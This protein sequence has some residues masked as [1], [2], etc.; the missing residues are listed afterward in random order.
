MKDFTTPANISPI[1]DEIERNFFIDRPSP[2]V[3]NIF[4]CDLELSPVD[5]GRERYFITENRD[6]LPQ[7]FT[8]IFKD[9]E[10]YV[11][12]AETYPGELYTWQQYEIKRILKATYKTLINKYSR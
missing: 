8:T 6:E 7:V 4:K 3:K 5:G 1:I 10:N 9:V 11:K 2:E 12:A